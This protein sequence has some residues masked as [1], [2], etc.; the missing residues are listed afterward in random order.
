VV[1]D[2]VADL[3]RISANVDI[4]NA[5]LRQAEKNRKDQKNPFL[6]AERAVDAWYKRWTDPLRQ[7]IAP[8]Q[9]A[10][11]AYGAKLDAERRAEAERE[12]AAARAEAERLATRAAE[13]LQRDE[14]S[15]ATSVLLDE[16]AEAAK[17]AEQTSALASGNSA[18]L[19]RT[20]GAYGGTVSGQEVW[21]WEVED[22]SKVPLAFMQIN[23]T[24]ANK[25]VAAFARSN[26]DLARKGVSPIPGLRITRTISMRNR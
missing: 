2:N 5:R 14:A 15:V 10:M 4:G 18:N 8:L 7:A 25:T 21:G 19:T 1:I 16:A 3:K 26:P 6:A 23:E 12:A 22:I 20:V 9:R 11:D 13:Q 24:L 17:R